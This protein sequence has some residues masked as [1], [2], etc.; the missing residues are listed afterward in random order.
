MIMEDS[1][2]QNGQLIIHYAKGMTQAGKER[3]E[4]T[5]NSLKRLRSIVLVLIAYSDC[6]LC[7]VRKGFVDCCAIHDNWTYKSI[8]LDA[9]FKPVKSV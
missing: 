1:F 6:V 8:F 5:F 2:T 7:L 4:R 3:K 9:F